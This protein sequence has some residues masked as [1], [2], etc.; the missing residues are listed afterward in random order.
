M[1]GQPFPPPPGGQWKLVDS[2]LSEPLHQ[3][4]RSRN[5]PQLNQP[6][7]FAYDKETEPLP[8]T[9]AGSGMPQ[10]RKNDNGMPPISATRYPTLFQEPGQPDQPSQQGPG[11]P[12]G[13]FAPH[14]QQAFQQ[15]QQAEP[16]KNTLS[17]TSTSE[18]PE[19][20]RKHTRNVSSGLFSKFSN[21]N[22]AGSVPDD[23]S[24]VHV[25]V[26][27]G[28][29]DAAS[30]M[31]TET[32]DTKEKKGGFLSNLARR[33]TAA[34]DQLTGSQ[35]LS[36]HHQQQAQQAEMSSPGRQRTFFSAGD[37]Q[38][39]Q[40]SKPK[41]SLNL[42]RTATNETTASQ[43]PTIS[44]KK[45]LSGLVDK[46]KSSSSSLGNDDQPARSGPPQTGPGP[47][48]DLD[49]QGRP[50]GQ[51]GQ[52]QNG[53]PSPPGA[54]VMSGSFQQQP[55]PQNMQGMAGQGPPLG[56]QF[57]PG[58]GP[59]T[60]FQGPNGTAPG[61]LSG[62]GQM[63]QQR[64]F[65]GSGP[66]QPQNTGPQQ[67]PPQIA[68]QQQQLSGPASLPSQRNGQQ[69][70]GPG[71][72]QQGLPQGPPGAQSGSQPPNAQQVHSQ[73]LQKRQQPQGLQ[74]PQPANAQPGPFLG[75]QQ[76][77][78]QSPLVQQST[79][80]AGGQPQI[81]P[82]ATGPNA[83]Q[84]M[85]QPPGA[86][87]QQQQQPQQTGP[88]SMVGS[89]GQQFGQ[90]P[91][92]QQ[93]QPGQQGQ[94]GQQIQPGQQFRPGQQPTPNN[95]GQFPQQGPIGPQGQPSQFGPQ[96]PQGGARPPGAGPGA[97]QKPW[98]VAT[99]VA[100]GQN[101]PGRKVSGFFSGFMNKM[102]GNDADTQPAESAAHQNQN[103]SPFSGQQATP[104]N[105]RPPSQLGVIPQGLQTPGQPGQPPFGQAQQRP[106]SGA[107]GPN[108][109][110][111]MGRGQLA[112]PPGQ[113]QP[114]IRQ[115]S[116]SSLGL[117]IQG[118]PPSPQPGQNFGQ[119]PTLPSQQT[120]Q[121]T[122]RPS[123]E[124]RRQNPLGSNPVTPSAVHDLDDDPIETAQIHTAHRISLK[125]SRERLSVVGLPGGPVRKPV[126]SGPASHDRS[127]IV[128][129]HTV[130]TVTQPSS[131]I[132]RPDGSSNDGEGSDIGT[133]DGVSRGTASP[134]TVRP[135]PNA[136]DTAAL[137]RQ[138]SLPTPSQ[139]PAPQPPSP[140]A[141][142]AP[143]HAPS[144]VSPRPSEA[145]TASISGTERLDVRP[146]VPPVQPG[147]G[148]Q[149]GNAP[150][151]FPQSQGQQ[152]VPSH[153][154][155]FSGQGPGPSGSPAPSQQEV[156][157]T[158]SKL[159]GRKDKPPGQT[160][161][162]G[163]P[164]EKKEK[165]SAKL[166]GAFRRASKQ[167]DQPA[168]AQPQQPQSGPPGQGRGQFPPNM[169]MQMQGGRGQ[170]PPQMQGQMQGG[171]GQGPMPGQFQGQPQMQMQ[172]GRGQF[173]PQMP[174]G[175]GQMPP[176]GPPQGPHPGQA[177]R[178]QPQQQQQ[179]PP[180]QW[181][182]GQQQRTPTFTGEQQYAPVPIPRGYEAVHGY[183]QPN[184]IAPS[185]YNVGRQYTSPGPA[186]QWN[187]QWGPPPPQQG[188]SGAGPM[189]GP[190]GGTAPPSMQQQQ[191]QQ[192]FPQ[193]IAGQ[194]GA[195]ISQS[196]TPAPM[197]SDPRQVVPLGGHQ[198]GFQGADAAAAQAQQSP[199]PAQNAQFSP[200]VQPPQN[201]APRQVQGPAATRPVQ[202]ALSSEPSQSDESP[203][204]TPQVAVPV[205]GAISPPAAG[206]TS[207]PVDPSYNVSPPVPEEGRAQPNPTAI[208]PFNGAPGAPT[209]PQPTISA[210]APNAQDMRQPRSTPA[211]AHHRLS[212]I[213]IMS[214][215]TAEAS[216]RERSHSSS[217]DQQSA[218]VQ[219]NGH[220]NL[221]AARA[222][223]MSSP[224][225]QQHSPSPPPQQ[226]QQQQQKQQ[227][228][229]GLS[230]N[231]PHTPVQGQ[232][233]GNPNMNINVA[234]AN[235]HRQHADDYYDATPRKPPVVSPAAPPAAQQE[236]AQ[237]PVKTHNNVAAAAAVGGAAAIMGAAGAA[238]AVSDEDLVHNGVNGHDN[239]DFEEKQ[240]VE[241]AYELPAV[242]DNSEDLLIMSATSYPGQEWNPYGAGEFGD[243]E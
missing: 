240:V 206:K 108:M 93:I 231:S 69:Q 221:L 21:R 106:P 110:G 159:F 18:V 26:D 120:S 73:V 83:Q 119:R 51:Q 192:Q 77:R 101:A 78:P 14:G 31:S 55:G 114:G 177:G 188:M 36:Q 238:A 45:R 197:G 241:E 204:I 234:Q 149:L 171:R 196:S 200:P 185:T 145:D 82:Q 40:Q 208:R 117:P 123:G 207:P 13:Q 209:A 30:I 124:F 230:P 56:Q 167:V 3:P 38:G 76:G 232:A 182:A 4:N 183:G 97:P 170:G 62:Q 68:Q 99:T 224:Q 135:Q 25:V 15:H 211:P 50:N 175:R 129:A 178:G 139:T 96:G 146:N 198:Q 195:P 111:G 19:H 136:P 121:S 226:Q 162:P 12:P 2:T 39:Q 27:G 125:S 105:Q 28:G 173:P 218:P 179:Q 41:S 59:P 87:Q 17:R 46:L 127:S 237:S 205:A 102:K 165:T 122:V 214:N 84:R 67:G 47:Q 48:Q 60:N 100:T 220:S 172:G 186:Q 235:G 85:S 32:S 116:Q 202:D 72:S 66:M 24:S 61:V 228:Q 90:N 128:S 126:G 113:L 191:Q 43:V 213:R 33:S 144:Q 190:Y 112:L 199:P 142:S 53:A 94:P 143:S 44:S 79:S 203:T 181:A 174:A 161:G 86:F 6:S 137:R 1:P 148:P 20:E 80:P 35:Q 222:M 64:Q 216:E 5:S 63:P 58:Q 158:M 163:Q 91:M 155:Q 189:G 34:V 164:A 54:R 8:A 104:A 156:S 168:S 29:G 157:G 57:R 236:Q 75:A 22:R 140:S 193:G 74:Q 150:Q 138:P 71:F 88:Q 239:R 98:G 243:F 225:Q 81:Q 147:P 107:G 184:M 215:R 219:Q 131:T 152:A 151:G 23:K 154:Q 10:R 7:Q 92:G 95:Q 42:V 223:N 242:N 160:S 133:Q 130:S 229:Q 89:S 118:G 153:Q 70:G 180:Q 217:P 103:T 49:M 194:T 52:F 233:G 115:T 176:Q 132:S 212:D 141:P 65:S 134:I 227:K 201:P 187:P 16:H 9:P 109:Y 169:Q 11:G 210:P 37:G 166:L